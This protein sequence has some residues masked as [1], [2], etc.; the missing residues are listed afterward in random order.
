MS[1]MKT[2]NL[3]EESHSIIYG[4]PTVNIQGDVTLESIHTLLLQM[5]TKLTSIELKN[6][7]LENRLNTIEGEILSL[8]EI[9]GSIDAMESRAKKLDN[10]VKSVKSE[11]KNL[12]TNVSSLG[13]VFD[14]VK[15]TAE[16]NRTVIN[17]NRKSLE[18]YRQERQLTEKIMAD[19]MKRMEDANEKLQNSVT[20][21]KA[22]SMRD[23]LLLGL[24]LLI[25][26]ALMKANVKIVTDE[27]KPAL[28]TVTVSSYK[29][30]DLADNLSVVFIV[31]GVFIFIV[32]GL[33]LFGA[34]CQNRCMLVTYAILVLVLFIAKIAAIALW[35]TMQGELD[36]CAINKV[37]SATNDFDES[38]W[39]K[40]T[41]KSC[42]DTLA[43]V[44]R[45]CCVNV[46]ASTY[47]AATAPC[48]TGVSGYN[49]MGCYDA[50]KA[51][52]DSYSTPV[53]GVGITIL[54]IEVVGLGLVTVGALASRDIATVNN[55]K[56]KPLLDSLSV[57][58]FSVG[59]VNSLS[60]SI[61]V[62]G[63]FIFFVAGLGIYGACCQNKYLL[64]TLDCCG[65]NPV[66]S[67][68]NDFDLTYW[69]TTS[70][71]C[72]DT[73]S[74]IPR[75]CC[76]NVDENTYTSAPIGCHASVNK[77]TYNPKVDV[78][79]SSG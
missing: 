29:L 41:G 37:T 42:K 8:R 9:R 63:V 38:P 20:D 16:A 35:F 22:R 36:C 26:G 57:D 11:F 73:I 2:S 69:C 49:T 28:N 13:E 46:D 45:T 66:V 74:Q 4:Q 58:S 53:I 55:D 68:T 21:L 78:N 12:E 70:G 72:E 18:Q 34:C 51:E 67:T 54:V 6:D 23:N 17:N 40:D 43:E 48:T 7:N 30:G 50:L 27:V 65:V 15:E 10:D 52:I 62:V 31:I 25:V 59:V 44:P 75:T 24:G 1:E 76:I 14:S 32:A 3:L 39:C 64:V 77:G 5:N 19:K 33:G 60:I 56:I 61:I 47:T 71:S 79:D